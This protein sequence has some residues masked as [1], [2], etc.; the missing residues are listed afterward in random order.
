MLVKR[1]K[2]P[3]MKHLSLFALL[4]FSLSVAADPVISEFL[5]SNVTGAQDEDGTRQD[6]IEVHNPDTTPVNLSGWHLTDNVG[7]PGKWTFPAVTVPAKGFLL[8]WASE[9]NRRNPA[10]P[11]HTNFKL[12]ANGEY[13]AL[14]RPDNSV[15]HEFAPSFPPQAQDVA[16]GVPVTSVETVVT[17]AGAAGRFKVPSDGSLGT[18]WTGSAFDDSGWTPVETGVGYDA[19]VPPVAGYAQYA[20]SVAEFSG[21][22]GQGGWSYGYWNRTADSNAQYQP[23]EMTAFTAAQW[24]GAVWDLNP[25]PSAPWTEVSSGGGHPNGPNSGDE[26]WTVRRWVSEFTGRARFVGNL[27]DGAECGDGV[28]LRIYVEGVQA[29]NKTT[30]SSVPV[31]FVV[32]ADVQAGQRV[33]FV[34]T[35]LANDSC[36]G[37]A[38]NVKVFSGALAD[39]VADWSG[40]GTQGSRRWNYGYYRRSADGDGIYQTANFTAFPRTAG[41]NVVSGTNAWNGTNWQLTTTTPVTALTQNGGTPGTTTAQDWPVRRWTSNFTG[42]VRIT[43][44]TGHVNAGSNGVIARLWL[45]GA[46]IFSRTVNNTTEGYTVVA[47]VTNGSLLDFAIDPNGAEAAD[48]NAIFTAIISEATIGA[49]VVA[50][51]VAGYGTGT[52]GANGWSHGYYN[53]TA[54]G[55]AVYDAA[56]FNSTDAA[57][58]L[59][60][61]T[62]GLG[63]GDP[64]WT[65]LYAR[66]GHPNGTN[67]GAVEHWVIHRWTSTVAG[68]LTVDWNLAK[69]AAGGTGTTVKVMHNGVERDAGTIAGADRQG[70]TR[71]VVLPGVAVGD[72]IDIALTPIGPGGATDDGGDGSLFSARILHNTLPPNITLTPQ[73]DS[74]ADWSAGGVQGYRGWSYG[75]Y[76]KTTDPGG[77]YESANFTQ[78]LND[79]SNV[80]S[81][82]NHWN[83]SM[84]DL[85]PGAS[86]P[87]TE[88]GQTG[89]HPNGTNSAPTQE[90]WTI[91]RW[92]STVSGPLNVS[93][94][95]WKTNPNGSGVSIRAYHNGIE[96]DTVA[97]AGTDSTGVTRSFF[98]PSANAGDFIDVALTPVG[99]GGATDD[100]ADGSAFSV[101]IARVTQFADN[102]D[103]GAG[104]VQAA[105]HG[106]NASAYLRVPVTGPA[107]LFDTLKLRMKFD[108]GFVAYLNGTEIARRSVPVA[109]AGGF[110]ADS[111][112]E[113]SG[114]QGQGNWFYG[115]WNQAG[116]A[117]GTYERE[118]FA[119]NDSA[120]GYA[121]SVWAFRPGSPPWTSLDQGGGHP[122]GTNSAGGVQHNIR[123][124]VAETAGTVTA[125][126]TIRKLNTA[127][128]TGITGHLKH[129]GRTVWSQIVAG[130]DGVGYVADVVVPDVQINDSLDLVMDATGQ[131]GDT[132]DGCDGSHLSMTVEQQPSAGLTWNSPA[133]SARA[134]ALVGT[135]EDFDITAHRH[136]L[137]PGTNVLAIHG[138]NATA[139]DPDFLLLPEL[140][141]T[142]ITL[143]AAG[144]VYFTFP[145]PGGVNGPGSSNIGPLVTEVTDSPAVSDA[146]SIVITAR[147]QPTLE[148]V[149][150]VT[151]HW[152]VM[153]G[154]ESSLTMLDDGLNGDALAGDGIF[155]A[156]IPAAASA[157]GQMVRWRVQA[158]DLSGDLTKSP[159]YGNVSNSPEYWGTV[160]SVP[161][162]VAGGQLPVLH[163]FTNN[164]AAHD[165]AGGGRCAIFFNGQFLDNVAADIH[166]QSSQGFPKKS[167]DF[168]LNTGF[169]L[170]WDTT[171]LN[172]SPKVNSFNLLTTYPDK[173]YLRNILSYRTLQAAGAPGHWAQAVQVR[174]N[175]AFYSVAHMVEDGDTDYL[176]R[177]PGLDDQGALYKMYDSFFSPAAGEKKTRKWE[178]NADLSAFMSGLG[179]TGVTEERFLYDNAGVPETINYL[180]AQIL[181][182]NDDCCHKNYYVYRDSEGNREWRPLPWDVDLSYGRVW[183]SAETYFRDTMTWDTSLFVGQGNQFMSPFLDGT[184]PVFRAM[185]LRRLRTLADTILQQT[186][187]PLAERWVENQ[188]TQL[189]AQI[190]PD[191]DYEDALNL[192]GT[193]GTPQTMAQA[194]DIIR[195]D[196]INQRRNY[197]FVTQ[198]V[199]PPSQSPTI[200]VNFGTVVF[201]PASHNQAEEYFTLVNPNAVAVDVSNWVIS[202][203][204]NH[205]LKPGTVIPAGGTLYLSPDVNAFRARAT[206]PKSGEGHFIQ[207]NYNGQLSARGETLTLMDGMRLVATTTYTGA[208]SAAQNFLRVTEMMYNA[209]PKPGDTFTSEEYEFIELK[210]ISPVTPVPLLGVQF[211][212]GI[213]F[214]FAGGSLAPGA[215]AVLVRNATA[216]AQRY[217]SVA[218]AGTYTGSLDNGGERVVLLD[219]NNEEVLDYTYED[220]WYPA[221][222]GGG[223][224][225][226][227]A[228]E[229]QSPDL[230]TLK[231]GWR[232]SGTVCGTPGSAD[233]ITDT[234]SDGYPDYEEWLAGTDPFS[235]QSVFGITATSF[236][237]GVISGSFEG[238]AGKTYTLQYSDTLQPG[239]WTNLQT[240]TPLANGTIT[241]N[242]TPPASAQRR[243][244]RVVTPAVP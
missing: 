195:N 220:D 1:T 196:Y 217:P 200:S 5:A 202:G 146:D 206:S 182:G 188:L 95:V 80:V 130:N 25:T 91:R 58:T 86:G 88:L 62:W 40:S 118:D 20:D 77:V 85:N 244:Y 136:L 171:P 18:A 55:N 223:F 173:A 36:D 98:I 236:T 54:D 139:G 178:S 138:L 164:A 70:L 35:P 87:W 204:V 222:D 57:W 237:G 78:F 99:P 151:L 103:A 186:S 169:K 231:I 176:Q 137:T 72:T 219:A 163:W 121:P 63:P 113:F 48:T 158:T 59:G 191:A 227:A 81:G 79:G 23:D 127:C 141:G 215:H 41:S 198:T 235:P 45:N 97:I 233:A 174:R 147:I 21:V 14:T 181:T 152:R 44:I 89:T 33:D 189:Q 208:P 224:S 156:T 96:R 68:P 179:S 187:V 115:Y 135:F 199:L 107:S 32:D 39:S 22:Q 94:K 114:V 197:V 192:W 157:P 241:I 226:V 90:H 37:H 104:N 29:Y 211:T 167:Y 26:H 131:G 110:F 74:V 218:I 19:P 124:W 3:A 2:F 203:A 162:P 129:N 132:T 13:L 128:G 51:S 153:Y 8:V 67:S 30:F 123:R 9:K 175:N 75:Y 214:T 24:T 190:Q 16:Y 180:A 15:A 101:A 27:S 66:G 183:R 209:G 43:G 221:T 126:V 61:T 149:N 117:N 83:G 207:G 52:Q 105:M 53:K 205:T 234:D 92:T 165:G 122:N 201:D 143:D 228:D 213:A 145:T 11:L 216:F 210:N 102:I 106:V 116:D 172:S 119:T 112:A 31:E 49:A 60:G 185:Y 34:I 229:N 240:F 120:W 239:S 134:T 159:P 42:R 161:N 71:S 4:T 28:A 193:W 140:A 184:Q 166:G 238:V 100:G 155:G 212:N 73:A 144:R 10:A 243:C 12:S 6:W 150:T 65:S 125:R 232:P 168:D 108:D 109:A 84:W 46:E 64:P 177:A 17:T 170:E 148:L 111:L 242:D 50:D 76:N 154:P 38:F 93:Y 47:D 230:W 82:T 133:T 69:A 56:D 225:L 7:N 194:V 142:D 160:V